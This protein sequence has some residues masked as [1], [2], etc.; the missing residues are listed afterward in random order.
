MR[1]EYRPFPPIASNSKNDS[2]GSVR[3][4]VTESRFKGFRWIVR[5]SELCETHNTVL[6]PAFSGQV[7]KSMKATAVN[8]MNSSGRFLSSGNTVQNNYG[9]WEELEEYGTGERQNETEKGAVKAFQQSL[10]SEN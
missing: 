2:N 4:D 8:L 3:I 5:I 10:V 9:E 1:R 7:S 6:N